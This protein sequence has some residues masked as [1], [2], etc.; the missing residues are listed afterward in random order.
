MT[1][2]LEV[3]DNDRLVMV[4]F[5]VILHTCL[6]CL[7][8]LNKMVSLI[9]LYTSSAMDETLHQ[10]VEVIY[11][12]QY[13]HSGHVKFFFVIVNYVKQLQDHISHLNY[14]SL[15]TVTG[16]YYAMDRDKRYERIKIAYDGIV[17]GIG[18]AAAPDHVIE[19]GVVWACCCYMVIIAMTTG[20]EATIQC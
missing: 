11:N 7:R 16:R 1:V 9:V 18:Q 8:L 19:V 13:M 20:D 17:N 3:H 15:A 12:E 5:T 4:E 6:L 2:L 14:G 10:L